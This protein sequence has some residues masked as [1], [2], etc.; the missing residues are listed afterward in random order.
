MVTDASIKE[1]TSKNLNIIDKLQRYAIRTFRQLLVHS[2]VAIL[3]SILLGFVL[4]S[5]ISVSTNNFVA[6][7]SSASAVPCSG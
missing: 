1:Q 3:L 2:L 7:I 5:Y 4:G 6:I